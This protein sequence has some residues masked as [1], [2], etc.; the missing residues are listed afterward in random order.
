LTTARTINGVSFDG[1]ANI[2]I[3]DSTKQ[4][5]DADLTAIAA[6]AG[7]SGL[8]RKTAA[9]TWSLDTTAYTANL[10]T[11][12]SVGL[13]LPSILTVSG[14][15][16]TTSGTLSATL[17]SQTANTVFAAPN[18]SAGAPT[19]RALVTADIPSLDASK[20]T[21]GTLAVANGGTG[22]ASYV[23]GDLVFASGTTT[24]SKLADVATGNVLLSG[25][26]G[27]APSYG[28]VGLTTHVSGTL[29]VANGG[30]GATTSTG[31]GSVVLSTSPTLTTPNIGVATGTSFNSITGLASVT[32]LVAGTAAVG[33]STAVARQDHVHPAQTS[34]SGNAGT[35][36]T[37]QTARTLTIG[38]TG[39]TFNGSA[40]V[41][42]SLAEMGAA[43]T[44][45]P[46]FTGTPTAPTATVTTN[47][48]QVA[49]TEFVQTKKGYATGA[50]GEEAFFLNETTINNSYTIPTNYNA[51]TFGPVTVADGV[52]I[53]VPDN[54]SWTVV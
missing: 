22:L 8:L 13:S 33:T 54:S 44:V 35:A 17:A 14:S 38:S 32:P 6:L 42:W 49:T 28:K 20:I 36:T 24:L 47:T 10:G 16:V 46:A 7:T 37:L 3:A 25:G 21:T 19:F 15:P 29:A 2:T 45:S 51:G 31:S 1:T 12:T 4:P 34:V 39:K 43:P 23:V 11:V 18:G 26:V 9:D 48:T 41:S 52:T 30:T 40:N 53:T 50:S 27:V 5:L